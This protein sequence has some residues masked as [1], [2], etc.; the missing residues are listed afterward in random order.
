MMTSLVDLGPQRPQS[1]LT[2]HLSQ[3][4]MQDMALLCEE[5]IFN[6]E[7]N[8]SCAG[9]DLALRCQS[10]ELSSPDPRPSMTPPG[11]EAMSL[12]PALATRSS[13]AVIADLKRSQQSA[14]FTPATK[15]FQKNLKQELDSEKMTMNGQHEDP[16]DETADASSDAEDQL[17]EQSKPRK[18]SDRKRAQIATFDSWFQS[19]AKTQA[20]ISSIT[21][22]ADN[23]SQS[24]KALVR[25]SESQQIISSPWEYQ[26]E[27]FE[28]AKER[29][30]I[31]VLDTG[32]VNP[33]SKIVSNVK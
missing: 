26:V 29:N 20:K 9:D 11:I 18:I 2:P 30:I 6:V 7:T 27:L 21:I 32:K 25:Q 33:L 28:R 4:T 13:D 8:H 12:A 22:D 15:R 3:A 16:E 17:I 5:P 1:P 10:N 24:I 14:L 23:E 31:A 19:Y